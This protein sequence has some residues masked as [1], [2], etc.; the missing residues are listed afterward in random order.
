M[1]SSNTAGVSSDDLGI[2]PRVINQ[3]FGE[4]EKR[5]S[6]SEFLLKA[7]FLEIYN[8]EIKDLLDTTLVNTGRMKYNYYIIIP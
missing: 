1:G 4:I 8:E 7:S 2:I 5:K 6:K 3:F